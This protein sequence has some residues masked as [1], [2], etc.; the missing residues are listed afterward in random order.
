MKNSMKLLTISATAAEIQAAV[1]QAGLASLA[2]E[3]ATAS[4]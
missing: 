1:T 3:I 4:Q 2:A